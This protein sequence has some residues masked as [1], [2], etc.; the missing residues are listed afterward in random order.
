M[1]RA[2]RKSERFGSMPETA[3]TGLAGQ[4]GSAGPG[5]AIG[6][7]SFTLPTLGPSQS[8]ALVKDPVLEYQYR[9]NETFTEKFDQIEVM[10][11]YRRFDCRGYSEVFGNGSALLA[12]SAI[13]D[14]DANFWP[15]VYPFLHEMAQKRDGYKATSETL[16]NTWTDRVRIAFILSVKCNARI[17]WS[18]Y[19]AALVNEGMKSMIPGFQGRR[20]RLLR[21]LEMTNT[22]IYPSAWDKVI[23]YWSKLYTPYQNGPVIINYFSLDPYISAGAGLQPA[24]GTSTVWAA[25][26]DWTSSTDVGNLMADLELALGVLTRFNINDANT[27]SDFRNVNSIYAMM[28]M[29]TPQT[30][31]SGLVVDPARFQAEFRRYGYLY[32]DTKGAGVDHHIYWPDIRGNQDALINIDTEG[33]PF[34]ELDS[35]GAKGLYAFD[36]DDDDTP[37]YTP[38]S[39]DLTEF[40][41]VHGDG[42]LTAG[43]ASN[44]KAIPTQIYTREDGW[45]EL[46]RELDYTSA[47][48]VQAHLWGVPDIT[49]HPDGWRVINSEENEE[50]YVF[51]FDFRTGQR[52]AFQ[53][54]FDHFGQAYRKWLYQSYGIP[55]IT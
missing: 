37:G 12:N 7:Q 22:I 18:A 44:V 5:A 42:W 20:S 9:D 35:I 51:R 34:D 38:E 25:L 46:L 33:L 47:S 50:G 55:Y 24:S 19:H 13:Y 14:I 52:G 1:G 3:T 32:N 23:D 29:P 8:P 15:N 11:R 16:N 26:P 4:R 21:I 40:G 53:R 54:P 17:L 2:N 49:V 48:G 36:A 30:G 41:I 27:K 43:M 10:T 39:N 28:G 45:A 31:V 6:S